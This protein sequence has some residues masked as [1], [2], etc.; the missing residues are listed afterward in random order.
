[1]V[2]L[3]LRS[4]RAADLLS[5]LSILQFREQP[6]QSGP[7]S[8]VLSGFGGTME[9]VP[10]CCR[11]QTRVYKLTLS[12]MYISICHITPVFFRPDQNILLHY[13]A[14]FLL[15]NPPF[16]ATKDS[17]LCIH[18][19]CCALLLVLTVVTSLHY[20][21]FRSPAAFRFLQTTLLRLQS[22]NGAHSPVSVA[23]SSVL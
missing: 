2:L 13:F 9:P 16:S 18:H 15:H 5:G 10:L 8:L 3:T 7:K 1:M 21:A 23:S 12:L 4:S 22:H 17:S 19:S 6:C 14:P 20:Q 11:S